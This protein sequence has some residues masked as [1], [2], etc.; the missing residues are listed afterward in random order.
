M[1]RK[2]YLDAG[3]IGFALF[4]MFFGAGNL[5]FPPYLGLN[6]GQHWLPGFLCFLLTDVGLAIM[7]VLVISKTEGGVEGVTAPLGKTASRL[8]LSINMLC[9]GP[10]IAIPRTAATTFEFSVQPFFPEIKSWVFSLAFFLLTAA[11]TIRKSRVIDLIGAVLAPLMLVGLIALIA[12]GILSP[13]GNIS[14]TRPVGET[15]R[16][17]ILAGYQTLDMLGGVVFSVSLL[18]TAEQK[19]Y[20]R[21]E[22]KVKVL[23]YA[24]LIAAVALT[25]VY[26]G[27]S[28]LGASAGSVSPAGVSRTGLL[29]F[30]ANRLMG[31]AGNILLGVIVAI[32]CLTTAVG[33][34]TSLASYF[35]EQTSGKLSYKA[36]VIGFSA[37]S[38]LLANLGV[39][40]IVELASPVLELIYPI[41]ITVIGFALFRRMAQHPMAYRC[42]AI[43]AMLFSLLSMLEDMVGLNLHLAALPL[44]EYGCGWVI[45]AMICALLGVLTEQSLARQQKR[46]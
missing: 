5:I 26:G 35:N 42:A 1:K 3:V 20:A 17:G 41:M 22:E 12:A 14:Y 31:K 19:G 38:C 11:L 33:L 8:L 32:A 28:Y 9:L 16:D 37:L 21:P 39:S 29:I 25:A 27:L 6:S 34:L 18:A 36:S 46:S 40:R 43:G 30:I 2:A 10:L 13:M 4:A 24:S 44:A 15:V 23:R 7:T 45:P